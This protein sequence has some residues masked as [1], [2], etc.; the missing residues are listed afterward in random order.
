VT[1]SAD[2]VWVTVIDPESVGT[3]PSG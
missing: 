3:S 1:A 2:D